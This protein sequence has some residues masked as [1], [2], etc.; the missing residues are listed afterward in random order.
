MKAEIESMAHGFT[1]L[2]A[3]VVTTSGVCLLMALSGVQKSMLEWRRRRRVC[4]SCGR[5]LRGRACACM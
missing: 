1:Q 4:P 2:A 5:E 3:L